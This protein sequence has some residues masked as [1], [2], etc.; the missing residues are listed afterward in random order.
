MEP[1]P[2]YKMRLHF[3]KS[4]CVLCEIGKEPCGAVVL[5][6]ENDL[7]SRPVRTQTAG[8]AP[9]FF[10]FS[11]CAWAQARALLRVPGGEDAAA[12]SVGASENPRCSRCVRHA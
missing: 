8:P 2:A 10:R 1:M 5:K 4:S 11:G 3:R 6:L 9:R 12:G 7:Q